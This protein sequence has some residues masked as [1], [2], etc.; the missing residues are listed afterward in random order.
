MELTSPRTASISVSFRLGIVVRL[1][2]ASRAAIRVSGSKPGELITAHEASTV[3]RSA[4]T[5][6]GHIRREPTVQRRQVLLL[7]SSC[8]AERLAGWERPTPKRL[9]QF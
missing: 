6:S 1:R 9:K 4:D 2:C 3:C 7:G 5:P 8:H